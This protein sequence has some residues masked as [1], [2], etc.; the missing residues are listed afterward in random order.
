MVGRLLYL[1]FTRPYI[2]HSFHLLGQFVHNPRKPHWLASLH[3]VK[4]LKS[5]L[6]AG[7]SFPADSSFELRAFCEADWAACRDTR[8]SMTSFCIYLGA[9]PVSWKSKKQ[10]TVSKSSAEAEYRSMGA[11]VCE[12]KWICYLLR[13]FGISPT[14]PI[15]LYCDN[16]VAVHIAKNVVFHERTKHLEIDCHIVCDKFKEG[17]ICPIHVP[18]RVQVAD[19]FTKSLP[20]PLFQRFYSKLGLVQI[21]NALT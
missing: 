1:G 4:Y 2:M 17:F 20:F 13:D 12:I 16:E 15:N 9:T 6:T 21:T 14:L 3:V 5:T 19:I 7:L 18:T 8:R 10:T 11:T